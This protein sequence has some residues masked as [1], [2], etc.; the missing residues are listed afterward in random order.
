MREKTTYFGVRTYPGDMA[1]LRALREQLQDQHPDH[2]VRMADA[3]RIAV[4]S[5]SPGAVAGA[6]QAWP[7]PPPERSG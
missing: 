2:Q 1:R 4:N 3:F 6:A 5:V 7:P